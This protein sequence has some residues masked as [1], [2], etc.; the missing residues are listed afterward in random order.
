MKRIALLL[1][2]L[3]LFY[4]A[5]AQRTIKMRNLWA[6]PQVHVTFN[7]YVVSFTLKDINRALTLLNETGDSTF[8]SYC[9]LDTGKNHFIEL[10]P[11][12]RMEYHNSLQPLL[13]NG[14]G[15]FLLLAGHAYIETPRHKYVPA[16]A[17]DI[18]PVQEGRDKALI[19][20]YDP[21]NNKML[22]SGQ[23]AVDMYNQD[24]GIDY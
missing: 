22:F 5:F 24:L 18:Q 9:A 14:V 6:R 1:I 3:V 13:Q 11:G 17:A 2:G 16:I 23:M 8:G 15:A 21:Q 10:Y 20:Y 4:S 19:L 12:S 7:G